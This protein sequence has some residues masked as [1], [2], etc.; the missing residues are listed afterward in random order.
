MTFSVKAPA[1]RDERLQ[2]A[3]EF[4][5]LRLM[6]MEGKG[7]LSSEVCAGF[8]VPCSDVHSS[9]VP[10]PFAL[11]ERLEG[12]PGEGLA[13]MKLEFMHVIELCCWCRM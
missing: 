2:Y 5:L 12:M 1:S 10:R 7:S 13:R 4:A 9:A 3:R 8:A 6:Q 11:A